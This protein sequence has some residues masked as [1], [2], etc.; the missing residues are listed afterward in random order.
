M[1]MR[2]P[3]G[4]ISPRYGNQKATE[5]G[6]EIRPADVEALKTEGWTEAEGQ[7]EETEPETD[8]E[9]SEGGHG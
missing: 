3:A 8:L 5:A 1:L 2:P 4:A 6:L 9:E 7:T